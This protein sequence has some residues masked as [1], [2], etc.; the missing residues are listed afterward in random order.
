MNKTIVAL[1]ARGGAP[2]PAQPSGATRFA[3]DVPADDALYERLG[4]RPAIAARW[5]VVAHL[6]HESDATPLMLDDGFEQVH[7]WRV[8]E[9]V[10]WDHDPDDYDGAPSI[11]IKQIS[12]VGKRPDITDEEF[13]ERY[14]DHVPVARIHHAGVRK[15]QQN[16]VSR[17][18]GDVPSTV[19][20]ISEFWF[21][22]VDDLIDRY[23]AFDD[24]SAVTRADSARFLDPAT[25]TWML[26]QEYWIAR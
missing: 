18:A 1:R 11:G 12:F 9:H 14:R 26:V 21:R 22:S 25:T 16:I 10:A 13:A 19:G 24:S 7:A 2:R 5:Q 17:V 15:Y 4:R 6:W 8:D 23:Y 3:I 20:G